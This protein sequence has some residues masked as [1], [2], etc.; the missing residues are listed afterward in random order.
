MW[1]G[2]K[3]RRRRW[4]ATQVPPTLLLGPGCGREKQEGTAEAQPRAGGSHPGPC[5]LRLHLFRSPRSE[6]QISSERVEGHRLRDRERQSRKVRNQIK[7]KK[8]NLDS[9]THPLN[10]REETLEACQSPNNFNLRHPRTAALPWVPGG[11]HR[12]RGSG[13]TEPVPP[14]QTPRTAALPPKGQR[15]ATRKEGAA[16]LRGT[17]GA[18]AQASWGPALGCRERGSWSGGSY[19]SPNSTGP[20]CSSRVRQLLRP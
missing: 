4:G 8:K 13:V 15:R 11:A 10:Y 6:G 18:P 12:A 17:P 20:H 7:N 3:V 14:S 16:V 5:G 19:R 1:G 9:Q 2:N